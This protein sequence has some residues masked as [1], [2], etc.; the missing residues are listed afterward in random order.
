M[1]DLLTIATVSTITFAAFFLTV[2]VW[3]HVAGIEGKIEV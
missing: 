2:L 1:P 3:E